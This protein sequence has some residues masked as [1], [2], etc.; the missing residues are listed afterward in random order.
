[1][2]FEWIDFKKNKF[3][4][5]A[6]NF[7]TYLMIFFIFIFIIFIIINIISKI[8]N[9]YIKINPV[10]FVFI[11]IFLLFILGTKSERIFY[12]HKEKNSLRLAYNK[13]KFFLLKRLNDSIIKE[14][15]INNIYAIIYDEF[16]NFS[17][18]KSKENFEKAFE[19]YFN[20]Y[21]VSEEWKKLAK[22]YSFNKK[23]QQMNEINATFKLFQSI[24]TGMKVYYLLS[25]FTNISIIFNYTEFNKILKNINYNKIKKLDKV[26]IYLFKEEKAS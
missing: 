3:K 26:Q 15:E 25:K 6:L 10:F 17:I 22:N 2:E 20:C 9:E 1:M 18:Y 16:H 4:D 11:G 12:R 7:S 21:E 23:I 24:Y 19:I 5:K 8:K 13:N 14:F